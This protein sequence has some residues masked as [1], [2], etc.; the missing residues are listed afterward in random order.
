MCSEIPIADIVRD[1]AEECRK[2][3]WMGSIDLN[4]GSLIGMNEIR[5]GVWL[6]FRIKGGVVVG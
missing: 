2:V 3:V 4:V 5:H 6:I 1:V